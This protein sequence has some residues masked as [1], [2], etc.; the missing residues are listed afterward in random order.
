M[1]D[2]TSTRD[3]QKAQSRMW[4]NQFFI[5]MNHSKPKSI[6][7]PYHPEIEKAIEEALYNIQLQESWKEALEDYK[8][9]NTFKSEEIR[10][11]ILSW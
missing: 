9:W 2:F 7:T 3:L 6:L 4:N 8:K 1:K 11:D 10:K 5:V